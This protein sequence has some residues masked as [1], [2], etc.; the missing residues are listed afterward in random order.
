MDIDLSTF[1]IGAS[2][3]DVLQLNVSNG[4]AVPSLIGAYYLSDTVATVP[5]PLPAVLFASGL[6]LL[7]GI[8]RKFKL[9]RR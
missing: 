1:N 8:G 2:P 9:A 6:G 4:S 7:A 3:V 5:L